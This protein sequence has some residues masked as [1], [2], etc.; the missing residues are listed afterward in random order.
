MPKDNPIVP[1][2]LTYSDAA[3]LVGLSRWT[4]MRRIRQGKL[5]VYV[6]EMYG[7]GRLKTEEVRALMREKSS[8]TTSEVRD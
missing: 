3:R 2:Y 1:E 4:I 5:K 6:S 7:G 8:L